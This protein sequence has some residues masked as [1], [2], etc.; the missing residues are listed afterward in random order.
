[1]KMFLE[2]YKQTAACGQTTQNYQLL[3]LHKQNGEKVRT[4]I[5]GI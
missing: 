4:I 2:R 5:I 3:G 1:M